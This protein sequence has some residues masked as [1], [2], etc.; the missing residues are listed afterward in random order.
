MA[1]IDWP[2]EQLVMKLW[3]T[4]AE[5]GMGKLLTPWQIKREGR[6]RNQVRKE[7]LIMLAHPVHP[8]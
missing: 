3:E 7:E 2:G 5:K 1:L 6:A 8:R 4:L